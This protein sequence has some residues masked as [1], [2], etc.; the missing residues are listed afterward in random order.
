MF[1]G[2]WFFCKS[3]P[4]TFLLSAIPLFDVT[5]GK[6]HAGRVNPSLS[7]GSRSIVTVVRVTD[8]LDL[9]ERLPFTNR[10]SLEG[11]CLWGYPRWRGPLLKIDSLHHR[12]HNRIV[13]AFIKFIN[14]ENMKLRRDRKTISAAHAF[15]LKKCPLKLTHNSCTNTST[16]VCECSFYGV[17]FEMN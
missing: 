2:S 1:L 5:T 12:S 17:E 13:C 3:K 14:A 6:S 7:D 9:P 15:L 16:H 4:F 8:S 11:D 10:S